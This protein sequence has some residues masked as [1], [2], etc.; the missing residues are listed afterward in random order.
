MRRLRERGWP[1]SELV[2]QPLHHAG[3]IWCLLTKLSGSGTTDKSK[4]EQLR[5]GRLLAQLHES[6]AELTDLGQRAGFQ[7]PHE[8]LSDPGLRG[9]LQKYEVLRPDTGYLLRWHL[10]KALHR[11][12]V[13]EVSQADKLVLHSDFTS[14]NVLYVDDTLTGI[15]D[16][17]ATH[18]N[19][20]VAD[21]A[22][23]WRGCYDSVIQGCE[24][25]RKLNDLDWQLL[26]PAFWSW[27]FMGMRKWIEQTSDE[28]LRETDFKWQTKLITRRSPL[29][30][31]MCEP[32][33]SHPPT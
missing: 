12:D 3:Q 28:E 4:D 25:V 17:E 1:V 6:T 30:G 18:L 26:V 16:F 21:F 24:E 2:E 20:R 27:L 19:Y 33:P 10:E 8:I 13:L 5:R 31:N 11:L 22:L 15:L 32:F 14:W 7:L 23:S 29:F 9:A